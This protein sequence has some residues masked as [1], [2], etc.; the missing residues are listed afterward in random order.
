M[1]T[2]ANCGT[3]VTE[4][5]GVTLAGKRRNDPPITMCTNC[6]ST[7]EAAFHT[8]TEGA[9]FVGALILGGIAAL[10]ASV[11]WYGIVVVTNYEV[12]IV[13]I[14]VGWLVANGVVL[15]AGRKRGRVLQGIS[16]TLT[17]LAM[18]AS[19]YLIL[20][21]FVVQVLTEEGVT[22]IPLLLPLDLMAEILAE[23]IRQD[24]L[25]L[26]FWALAVFEAYKIPARRSLRVL[27]RPASSTA[28]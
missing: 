20:R 7:F 26:L 21:Y 14:A 8:E 11:L 2:C 25:T 12:G 9:N 27:Q 16:I 28:A 17:L 6:A 10:A 22:G 24:P 4:G 1:T 23:S 13:A 18:V 5:F 19:Q 3:A 15:G